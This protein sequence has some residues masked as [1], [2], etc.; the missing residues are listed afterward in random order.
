MGTVNASRSPLES[1]SVS[2][3][4]EITLRYRRSPLMQGG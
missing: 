1:T 2:V 4:V 3:H